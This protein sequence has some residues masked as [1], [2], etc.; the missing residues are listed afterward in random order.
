MYEVGTIGLIVEIRGG[1]VNS[2][3]GRP[4]RSA[5][6]E[7]CPRGAR[8]SRPAIFEYPPAV[9]VVAR[10]LLIVSLGL[11]VEACVGVRAVRTLPEGELE[12]GLGGGGPIVAGYSAPEIVFPTGSF[13]FSARYGVIDE[14]DVFAAFE[15]VPAAFGVGLFDL[16]AAFELYPGDGRWAPYLLASAAVVIATD[17]EDALFAP[18]ATVLASWKA[19]NFVPYIGWDSVLQVYPAVNYGGALVTGLRVD[20]GRFLYIWNEWRWYVPWEDGRRASMRYL[21]FAG[22]GVIAVGAGM[23]V[24]LP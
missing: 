19:R 6:F 3:I 4:W 20:A 22:A 8:A 24:H 2:A 13:T 12:I 23:G 10:S 11:L 17:G 16:G 14:I 15:V 1:W 9:D 18:Q 5:S 21:T 7:P